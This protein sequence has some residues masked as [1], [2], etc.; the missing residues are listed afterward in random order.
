MIAQNITH[1]ENWK[2]A[3]DDA[4]KII[5]RRVQDQV[6][7]FV[8]R[9]HFG[10]E[11]TSK[12]ATIYDDVMFVVLL[13]QDIV[14]E[15]HVIKHFLLTS[16]TGALA[17]SAVINK[18]HII[19]VPVKVFRIPGPALYTPCVAMKIKNK[20]KRLFAIKVKAIDSNASLDVKK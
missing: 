8:F 12:T 15:L 10:G 14:Y 3:F 1:G 16:L 18:D 11:S 6:S 17:K 4:S 7:W 2:E 5:I 20:A 13:C 19:I 9:S